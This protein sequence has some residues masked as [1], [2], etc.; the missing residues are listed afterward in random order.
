MQVSTVDDDDDKV[1]KAIEKLAK[2]N[3]TLA[4]EVSQLNR[5]MT[6]MTGLLIE[7]IEPETDEYLPV[8]QKG[9]GNS[10]MYN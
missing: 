1:L 7:L 6:N 3:K 10:M 8:P 2:E 9:P 5:I 4:T